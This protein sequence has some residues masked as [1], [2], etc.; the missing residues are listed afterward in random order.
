MKVCFVG[1]VEFSWHVLNELVQYQVVDAVF[2]TDQQ[3]AANISDYKSTADIAYAYGIPYHTFRWINDKPVAG[4]L[5]SYNPDIVLCCGLSQLIV[6]DTLSIPKLGWVGTHP[7][8][9]PLNRG[10]ASIPW[11][12]L[13]GDSLGGLTFF[14]L[15][16]GMDTGPL[17]LQVQWPITVTDTATTLYQHMIDAGITGIR[18]LVHY[19]ECNVIPTTAQN[20]NLATY[21]RKRTPEDGRI[22]WEHM[23]VDDIDRLVR[24][25]THPY[26]GAFSYLHGQKVKFW[27]IKCSKHNDA[28]DSATGEI[29]FTDNKPH[30]NLYRVIV[31]TVH[32]T[33]VLYTDTKLSD[34][35]GTFTSEC[36]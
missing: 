7:S 30:N 6:A 22:I 19:F 1:N 35:L 2:Q 5:R 28:S 10:R 17:I 21:T 32:G 20:G 8:L 34:D 26:P 24:A 23:N 25:T 16:E 3:Y 4:E 33:I 31:G 13:H 18:E 9:L 14:F 27:D 12:I 11:S 29:V 15:D 36:V